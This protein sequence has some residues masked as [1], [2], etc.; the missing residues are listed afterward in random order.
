MRSR[1]AGA[2]LS[3]RAFWYG[4]RWRWVGGATA[5]DA[6]VSTRQVSSEIDVLALGGTDLGFVWWL[7]YSVVPRTCGNGRS[8]APGRRAPGA[9]GVS[10]DDRLRAIGL[11]VLE[12]EWVSPVEWWGFGAGDLAGDGVAARQGGGPSRS[13]Q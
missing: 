9:G 8:G 12:L 2:E 6:E 13:G 5:V 7:A 11:L 1:V 10:S 3:G 4:P